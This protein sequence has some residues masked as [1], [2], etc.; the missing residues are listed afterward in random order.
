MNAVWEI[1][2]VSWR[3]VFQ[4]LPSLLISI[5]YAWTKMYHNI[6]FMDNNEDW[7]VSDEFIYQWKVYHVTILLGTI[8]T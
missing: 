1:I 7:D 6:Q 3:I 2:I 5:L 8:N 4:Y